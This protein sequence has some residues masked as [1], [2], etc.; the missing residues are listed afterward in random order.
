MVFIWTEMCTFEDDDNMCSY[1]QDSSNTVDWDVKT[2]DDPDVMYRMPDH[3]TQSIEGN[4]V[5]CALIKGFQRNI[6][7]VA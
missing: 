4:P 1:T 3:T 5:I 7:F 2:G 6:S